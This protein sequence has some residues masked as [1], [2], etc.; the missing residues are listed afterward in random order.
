MAL[1]VDERFSTSPKTRWIAS[2]ATA[3]D[4]KK[5]STVDFVRFLSRVSIMTRDIDIEILSDRPSV[6]RQRSEI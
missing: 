5:L 6:R 2:T 1:Y 3:S 4:S